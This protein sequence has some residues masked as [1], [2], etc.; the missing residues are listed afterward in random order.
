MND[1]LIVFKAFLFSRK[2][3]KATVKNYISDV[4]R[5]IKWYEGNYNCTF[6]PSQTTSYNINAYFKE[7]YGGQTEISTILSARSVDRH[8][9]SLKKFFN[10]LSDERIIETN[11]LQVDPTLNHKPSLKGIHVKESIDP[12][13]KNFKDYLYR[14]NLSL[15]HI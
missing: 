14:Q 7:S 6:Q 2:H 12:V 8:H 4:S 3:S 1:T 15:I 11:P 13:L 9:A 5:Y 10:F